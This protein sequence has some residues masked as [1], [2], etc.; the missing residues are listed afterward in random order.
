[1]VIQVTDTCQL[2]HLINHPFYKRDAIR[3][4][5]RR[6]LKQAGLLVLG[7]TRV[8]LFGFLIV[9]MTIIPYPGIFISALLP[10]TVAWITK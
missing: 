10:V 3:L 4:Y 2:H 9:I 8:I 1:M 7:I 5:H 6:H